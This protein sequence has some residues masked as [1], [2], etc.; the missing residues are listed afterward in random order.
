MLANFSRKLRHFSKIIENLSF[1]EVPGRL[2]AY[3][4]YL[5]NLQRD[6]FAL[7]LQPNQVKLDISKGQLAALL[8]T[9]PETISRVFAKLSQAGLIEIDG[10]VITLVNFPELKRLSG[11]YEAD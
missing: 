10:A 11:D 9:I 4:L 7:N 5:H 1:K 2:A 8:T 6:N 3:L